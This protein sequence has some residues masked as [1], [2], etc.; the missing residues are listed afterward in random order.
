MIFK[1]CQ[2]YATF[3]GVPV[4]GPP[5]PGVIPPGLG[6]FIHRI[7]YIFIFVYVDDFLFLAQK[8]VRPE[9]EKVMHTLKQR[10]AFRDP[11]EVKQ[12]LNIRSNY[13]IHGWFTVMVLW[14]GAL[15]FSIRHLRSIN[16]AQHQ[17]GHLGT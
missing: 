1:H 15:Q 8:S 16:D 14:L 7:S 10:Y 3:S 11:G 12:F 4:L 13:I 17:F 9:L 6:S 2:L 5:T